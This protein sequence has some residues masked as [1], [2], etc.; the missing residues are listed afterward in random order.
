[1]IYPSL[2]VNQQSISNKFEFYVITK[3][4]PQVRKN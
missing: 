1:L 4:V 2:V 3:G